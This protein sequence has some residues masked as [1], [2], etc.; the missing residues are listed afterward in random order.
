MADQ[1]DYKE[2]DETAE[3]NAGDGVQEEQATAETAG[4]EGRN[5]EAMMG[6][7]MDVQ[8]VLGETQMKVSELLKLSRGSVIELEKKIGSPVD[9]MIND[10]VVARGDLVKVGDN[11][12]G[13][14]LT[15]IV[16]NFV[17]AG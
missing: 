10:R 6:V 13:V 8:I 15:E 17:P 9:V 3:A 16:K 1:M 4:G 14:T 2:I 5:V 7:D 11:N 12:V